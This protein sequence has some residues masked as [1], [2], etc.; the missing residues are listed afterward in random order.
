MTHFSS[1]FLCHALCRRR[2]TSI[3]NAPW[4]SFLSD[5]HRGR[6]EERAVGVL[7]PGSLPTSALCL[8]PWLSL[9]TTAPVVPPQ[10]LT[11]LSS[12]M[13]SPSALGRGTAPTLPGPTLRGPFLVRP[14]HAPRTSQAALSSKSFHLNHMGMSSVSKI[15]TDT[16]VYR[17][18]G[19]KHFHDYSYEWISTS[20][21]QWI[22]L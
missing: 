21:Y 20:S 15:L 4:A 3:A 18:E 10:T 7:L 19:Q 14:H 9:Q 12:V 1:I 11:V 16:W 13:S 6:Q 8:G 17:T 22:P 2:L 5:E